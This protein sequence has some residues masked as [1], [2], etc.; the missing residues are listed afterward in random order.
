[1]ARLLSDGH[2]LVRTPE[3]KLP[4]IMRH[5]NGLYS[6][7]SNRTEGRDGTVFQGRY[8]AILVEAQAYGTHL[9][10]SIHRHPLEAGLVK[11]LDRYRWSSYPAYI[12]RDKRPPWLNCEYTMKSLA[13]RR[14][15]EAYQVRGT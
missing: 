6:Q 8:K 14:V 9:S 11:R 5:I 3:A 15:I 12:G 1:M 4:R 2:L 10:R 7:Y 13:T